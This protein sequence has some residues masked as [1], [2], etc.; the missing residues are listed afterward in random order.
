MAGKT[1]TAGRKSGKKTKKRKTP[2]DSPVLTLDEAAD[3]LR[4]SPDI[5]VRQV[6]HAGMP[7]RQMDGEWR[8]YKPA[9]NDWLGKPNGTHNLPSQFG[10]LSHDDSLQPMLDSIYEQRG[11]PEV[12]TAN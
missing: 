5:V 8:F 7:G 4:L 3:Y 2:K 12:E 9:L 10:A 11:R 6:A 1:A